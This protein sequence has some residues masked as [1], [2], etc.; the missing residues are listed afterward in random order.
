MIINPN[1][2]RMYDIRG[3]AGKDISEEFSYRLGRAYAQLMPKDLPRSVSVGRDCRLSSK[4][5]SDALIDGLND[6]GVNTLDLGMVPTPVLYFSLFHR[7][8]GGGIVI[9]GSHNPPEDNGFKL[10]SGRNAIYG[11][12]IQKLAKLM[13]Q[14]VLP[15]SPSRG[16][17]ESV[18]LVPEYLDYMEKNLNLSRP[19]KVV[20]DAGNGATSEIAPELFE[21][22][23]A[24]VIPLFC[25]P[26]GK[27]PNHHPDPTQPETLVSLI[28]EVKRSG[29]EIGIAFDGDGD[30]IGVVDASGRI[31]W[32]DELLVLFSRSILRKNPG[33][34]IIS[35]VKASQRLYQEIENLGGKPLMWKTGHSLIK[36]KM[37]ETG[38]LLAGEMSGH[39]F[40]A[41][42]YFG[43]DDALYAAARLIELLSSTSKPINELLADLPKTSVTPEIRVPCEDEKKFSVVDKVRDHFSKYYDVND[44]DGVRI[45]FSDGWGLVRASNT[46]PALVLRFE[47]S[48][49]E[50]LEALQNEVREIVNNASG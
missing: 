29:A 8:L 16:T 3:R 42:R 48:S 25:S 11:P 10:S 33:A 5:Y 18:D 4:I 21:K 34:M 27:F 7:D 17:T 47:A 30:R 9:T 40:F 35:E 12:E 28:E 39:I 38:A 15:K 31:Y 36:S 43:Y 23:G 20:I 45:N 6:G 46:Q 24:D 14:T 50:K 37:R 32:G 13:S 49:D 26:D 1:I 44:I 19:M 2:F 41:D 22:I